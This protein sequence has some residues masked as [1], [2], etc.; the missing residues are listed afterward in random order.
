MVPDVGGS[1]GA[2]RSAATAALATAP[3][4]PVV[5]ALAIGGLCAVAA[6]RL[7]AVPQLAP[8][9]VL[10]GGLVAIAVAD[11]RVGL[12]PR[13]LLY[14]TLLLVATGLVCA[15]AADGAWRP[16][17]DALIGGVGAFAVFYGLWAI[18][19]RGLGFGDVRLAGLCG[20][21]LGWLGF[22][23]LYLGFLA[24]FVIGALVGIGVLVL[25]RTR[26]FPFAPAL[27]VGTMAGVLWGVWAGHAWL[28]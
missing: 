18:Y 8:Y 13:K 15:S 20:G 9:C 17:A 24:S 10:A 7:G 22:A 3:G 16:L 27:A 5:V 19:R 2:D 11:L 25:R 23:P 26:R 12:V 4:E 14:P 28:G 21:A 6:V 1:V